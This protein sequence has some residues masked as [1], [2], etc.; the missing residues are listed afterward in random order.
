MYAFVVDRVKNSA[1]IHVEPQVL[2]PKGLNTRSR[3]IVFATSPPFSNAIAP[4]IAY[5]A[6]A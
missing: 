4:I 5:I 6:R 2:T 3:V 1:I